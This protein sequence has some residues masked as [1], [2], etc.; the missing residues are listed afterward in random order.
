M[1]WFV[2]LL[3]EKC[4]SHGQRLQRTIAESVLRRWY[5]NPNPKEK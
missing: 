3:A 4:V 5:L 2:S 1:A